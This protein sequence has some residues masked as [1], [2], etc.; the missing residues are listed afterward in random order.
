MTKPSTALLNLVGHT[1]LLQIRKNVFAKLEATNPSGSI[2]DRMALYMLEAAEKDGQIKPG[3]EIVEATSGNTGIA[4]AMIAA[5]KGYSFTAIMAR[6]MSAERRQMMQAYGARV[7]FTATMEDA[8]NK[9][10]EFAA[11]ERVWLPRQFDNQTN[12]DCHRETTGQELLDQLDTID[13]FVAGVGTG[14]TLMGVAEALRARFPGVQIV[15]VEPKES[16]VLSGGQ[17]GVHK[18]QGIG[19]GFIP[20]IVD[21]SRLDDVVKVRSADAIK[22]AR[23]LATENGLFVGISS[24]ANVLASLDIARNKP[25]A[26]IV[27][28][29]PDSANRY[30]SVGIF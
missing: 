8:V 16:C 9:L 7:L 30:L 29:L 2:K 18:I 17:A 27:T 20:K 28:V 12:V 1:P 26:N 11:S 23:K 25:N 19:S 13:A 22:M 10:E 3:Y 6:T 4:F 5:L 24:G 14:G 21:H 15:A